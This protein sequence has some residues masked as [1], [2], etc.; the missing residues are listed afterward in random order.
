L[1]ISDL[2]PTKVM[3]QPFCAIESRHLSLFRLR[4]DI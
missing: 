2:E 1:L 4:T 3:V